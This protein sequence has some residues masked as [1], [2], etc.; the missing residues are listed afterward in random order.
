MKRNT[1]MPNEGRGSSKALI[2]VSLIIG[3]LA[4]S[5]AAFFVRWAEAPGIVASFYRMSIATVLMALPF[6]K[7]VNSRSMVSKK[8]VLLAVIGGWAFALDLGLWTTGVMLGE[9][10]NPTLLANTAPLWVGLGTVLIFRH[11]LK[12]KFWVGIILALSGAAILLRMD[13]SRSITVGLGSFLGLL[14]GLF[15]AAYWLLTQK[16][17]ENLDSLSYFWIATL[18]SGILLTLAVL[19]FR[20]PLTGYPLKSYLS[21]LG[22]GIL[23][24]IIGWMSLN[25]ALGSLPASLVSPTMLG[26]PLLT[27]ILA[28][29]LLKE[30][31]SLKQALAG[32]AVLLGIFLV[33]RSHQDTWKSL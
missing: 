18:S 5:M 8:G 25:Y 27:G 16:G 22:F 19:V 15:Y 2:Y 26:Q 14:A 24:Q 29:P 21:F 12:P 30:P 1:K 13:L 6:F 3:V 11:R 7:R 17:R 23:T 20:L 10:V 9:A 28:W 4:L 32:I 31:L 33:H